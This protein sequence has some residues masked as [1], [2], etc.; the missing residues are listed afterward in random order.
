MPSHFDR[1]RFLNGGGRVRNESDK[2]VQFRAFEE[3][4]PIEVPPGEEADI[5]STPEGDFIMDVM[6]P[7]VS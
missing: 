4:P 6:I 2:V 1:F 7:E 3:D 5:P